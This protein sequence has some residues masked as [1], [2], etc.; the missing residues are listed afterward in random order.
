MRRLAWLA[1]LPPAMLLLQG[2]E[3]ALLGGGGAMAVTAIEDRRTS[4]T[5][6]DDDGIETRVRRGVRENFGEN[7]HVN[8]TSFNRTV[9]LTGEVPNEAARAQIEK[10]VLSNA[11]VRGVTN[12]LQIGPVSSIPA[13]ANDSLITTK[14]KGRVLDSNK[15]N[16]VHVK[17]VTEAG[18]AYLLG[19]VTEAEAAD[20]VEIA[21]TT[22]GV[23][24]VVK[25][26]EYCK[27]TD[28]IC[29]P[30]GPA[31]ADKPQPGA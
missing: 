8:V 26:F 24:K 1:C 28:A 9:L 13:R 4:G 11:N 30:R 14:I 7:T 27:P 25:I 31:P 15:L 6:F 16:P 21:R 29:R 23:I 17:V 22:G 10:I 12:E 18:V 19:V 5:M 2:C 20:A 3:V